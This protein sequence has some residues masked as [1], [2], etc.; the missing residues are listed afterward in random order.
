M[1]KLLGI[2]DKRPLIW[3]HYVLLVAALFGGYYLGDLVLD[4][5]SSYSF[6]KM[7]IWF[8]VWIGVTDQLI[9]LILGVD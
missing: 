6:I 7:F 1:K 2:F 5:N 9:H 3:F 8:F 4:F